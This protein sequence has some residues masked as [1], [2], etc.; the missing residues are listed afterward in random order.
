MSVGEVSRPRR[1]STSTSD[2]LVERDRAVIRG[3]RYL[4]VREVADE[5]GISIGFCHQIFTEKLQMRCVSSC[6]VC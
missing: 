3:N 1:D 6:R 4:T 5:V 2:D